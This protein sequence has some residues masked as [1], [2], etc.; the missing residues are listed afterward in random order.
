M[1]TFNPAVMYWP[2]KPCKHGHN[3]PY[4]KSGD[5]C[6]ACSKLARRKW[7]IENADKEKR[8]SS[9]WREL[10]RDKLREQ[11]RLRYHSDDRKKIRD[12]EWKK[13]NRPVLN[14]LQR[15][16][17]LEKKRR[18]PKWADLE[19]IKDVY[20]LAALFTKET[21]VR[22]EVDH[23]VPLQGDNVCGFHVA[24]NMRIVP[25]HVNQRKK[26]YWDSSKDWPEDYWMHHHWDRPTTPF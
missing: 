24:N 8:A 3:A 18:I 19:A 22:H 10:N 13:R 2:E 9:R 1:V 12:R 4:Y 25:A 15:K 21:V 14:A 20:R 26:N 16:R 5:A 6:V 7:R 17:E 23:I 11:Q